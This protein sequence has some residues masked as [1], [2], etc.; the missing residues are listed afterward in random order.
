[1]NDHSP[2]ILADGLVRVA[3]VARFLACSRRQVHHLIRSGKLPSV[4]VGQTRRI[5][6]RG[7]T[8]YA[9]RTLTGGLGPTSERGAGE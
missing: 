2:D 8:E 3:E 7:L 9:L 5:P 1:M 4:V 6:R